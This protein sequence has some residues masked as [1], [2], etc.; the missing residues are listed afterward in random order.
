M[1]IRIRTALLTAAFASLS[2]MASVEALATTFTVTE[3]GS[4]GLLTPASDSWTISVGGEGTLEITL[5]E[6]DY[7]EFFEWSLSG[8]NALSDGGAFLPL[9][10]VGP[11]N[12]SLGTWGNDAPIGLFSLMTTNYPANPDEVE[13]YTLQFSFTP[14]ALN[15]DPDFEYLL[16]TPASTVPVP[17]AAWLLG[18]GLL[19]LVGLGRRQRAG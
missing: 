14:A 9:P 18:G 1:A 6:A 4:G 17:A 12:T 15:S 11:V 2:L 16:V 19:G 8:P 13:D 5:V 10:W 3:V 7:S